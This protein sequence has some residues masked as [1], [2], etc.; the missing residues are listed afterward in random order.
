[1]GY[2]HYFNNITAT[3]EQWNLINKDVQTILA[4]TDIP[5]EIVIEDN[6]ICIN[7]GTVDKQCETLVIRK[8]INK[9]DFCKTRRLPY[10]EIVC[11]I[12]IIYQYH[13]GDKVD[14]SS[15]GDL[16]DYGW[17][18]A[19]EMVKTLFDTDYLVTYMAQQLS[20]RLSE[21]E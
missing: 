5:L 7:G 20:A 10:D 21:E 8:D 9:W 4:N 15:D 11:A 12:L 19:Y 17:Q 6:I 18:K 13:M 3:D 16:E 14:V 2:T 1:M